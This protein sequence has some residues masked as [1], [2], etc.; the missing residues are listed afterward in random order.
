MIY[1]HAAGLGRT[2]LRYG[3]GVV[4]LDCSLRR[5]QFTAPF[6]V[7]QRVFGSAVRIAL[8]T[9]KY[10]GELATLV[11]KELKLTLVR[12][13]DVYFDSCDYFS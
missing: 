3:T 11:S 13:S 4:F 12:P 8:H 5:A 2:E 10:Q 1:V 7:V 9:G 6:A